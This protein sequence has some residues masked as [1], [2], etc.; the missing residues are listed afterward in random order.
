MATELTME[1]PRKAK[2]VLEN[3]DPPP[4]PIYGYFG[5]MIIRIKSPEDQPEYLD[6]NEEWKTLKI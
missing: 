4:Y 3:T 2:A 5:N 1:M 6:E